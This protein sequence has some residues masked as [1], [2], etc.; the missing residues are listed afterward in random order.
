NLV[1]S[2][3]AALEDARPAIPGWYGFE[4]AVDDSSGVNV[5]RDVDILNYGAEPVLCRR[6]LQGPSD[7]LK[8]GEPWPRS[9]STFTTQTRAAS[10]S[11]VSP[12]CGSS[13]TRTFPA[14]PKTRR[15]PCLLPPR[16][17]RPEN[18]C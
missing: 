16:M 6:H 15:A 3:R 11:V 8:G 4:L 10:S 12:R 2:T 13:F 17:R 18:G 1:R 7:P 14:L 9:S 5:D